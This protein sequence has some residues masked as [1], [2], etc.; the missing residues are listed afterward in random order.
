MILCSLGMHICVEGMFKKKNKQTLQQEMFEYARKGDFKEVMNYV[1][2]KKAS[3]DIDNNGIDVLIWAI[4]HADYPMVRYF[5][6]HSSGSLSF[7]YGLKLRLNV[8]GNNNPLVYAAMCCG[9]VKNIKQ[10][11]L[12]MQYLLQQCGSNV[13]V[14][15]DKGRTPFFWAYY[16][17]NLEMVKYLLE[18]GVHLGPLMEF[19]LEQYPFVKGMSYVH[20]VEEYSRCDVRAQEVCDA[21]C[22]PWYMPLYFLKYKDGPIPTDILTLNFGRYTSIFDQQRCEREMKELFEEQTEECIARYQECRALAQRLQKYNLEQIL[23]QLVT[24]CKDQTMAYKI[25]LN[26][27][28][29][30]DVVFTFEDKKPKDHHLS[31]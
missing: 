20:Y 2:H 10:R 3:L 4:T 9:D 11:T 16:Y 12:I 15:D 29:T 21:A 25:L 27:K 19:N 7:L 5:V 26:K 8:N 17:H 18:Q 24:R 31:L 28:S 14:C 1:E 6:E 22:M 30:K 13:D 23:V